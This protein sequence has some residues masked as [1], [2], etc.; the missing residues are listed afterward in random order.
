MVKR[1]PVGA[2][3]SCTVMDLAC[4]SY[5]QPY[6]GDLTA[7]LASLSLSTLSISTWDCSLDAY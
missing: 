5:G 6:N 1:C 7:Y 2:L 4:Q 3:V